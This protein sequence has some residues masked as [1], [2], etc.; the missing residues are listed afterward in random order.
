[1]TV[2]VKGVW[3]LRREG[4]SR[5]QFH[6]RKAAYRV[7]EQHPQILGSRIAM[8]G[9]SLGSIV[10]FR[11]AVY[12]QVVKLRCAV[13]I[14]GSHVQ[15]ID[16]PMEQMM[17]Y[18]EE[19]H[20]KSRFDENNYLICR[21][22]LLPIPTD[23][24]LKVDVGRLQCPLLLVVGEDDQNWPAYESAADIK[25]MMERAGNSHL[26]TVLTYKNAGHLI[27]PAFSPFSRSSA[28]KSIT[29]VSQKMVVLWGGEMVTHSR[30]Q[31]DSWRKTLVFLKENLYGGE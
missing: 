19:N 1:M 14:S 26:L 2:F 15:P 21:D 11:L 25:D 24:S 17:S 12:S 7:L 5:L 8:L 29:A 23:P 22:L 20:A 10:T 28:F 31:E 6:V 9:L 16:R 30:A 3:W 13:C 18:F 27:E 4:R